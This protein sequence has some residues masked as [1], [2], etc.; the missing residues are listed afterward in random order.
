MSGADMSKN[1]GGMLSQT[2]GA[3]GT[4]GRS[5]S[6]SLT[7]NIENITRPDAD[8]TDIASQQGLMQWQN[9]MGRT[10]EAAI[11]QSN[12]QQLQATKIM[13][14]E[15]AKETKKAEGEARIAKL[16]QAM[17]GIIASPAAE[18]QGA[19]TALQNLQAA[20]T[21]EALASGLSPT[22]YQDTLTT[23][24]NVAL[25][26]ENKQLNIE[27]QQ[28][29]QIEEQ[30][31]EALSQ[32]LAST[33]LVSEEG[34]QKAL[35]VGGE[36]LSV[37]QDAIK[38]AQSIA[39]NNEKIATEQ[40]DL[41]APVDLGSIDLMLSAFADDS[42]EAVQLRGLK[43]RVEA[44]N[45]KLENPS[46]HAVT[47]GEKTKLTND[48]KKILDITKP[49]YIRARGEDIAN[50]SVYR[51]AWKSASSRAS[52]A[53]EREAAIQLLK[54]EEIASKG[55]G[56]SLAKAGALF[57]EPTGEEIERKVRQMRF[58]NINMEHGK[59][60]TAS[61]GSGGP[62]VVGAGTGS[63]GTTVDVSGEGWN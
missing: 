10:K 62:S 41:K 21:S 58:D 18:T 6:D 2:A 54:S 56:I 9:N 29:K 35:A 36:Y 24:W 57:H 3:L 4:M 46:A 43:E 48:I 12:M 40:R 42:Q 60:L 13:E 44:H 45:K 52:T 11:T 32:V 25:D 23:A 33:D 50:D 16:K 19:K 15:K 20:I 63:L 34:Q 8:P 59:E 26:H 22:D 53:A 37:V 38:A 49:A 5:Y 27:S 1:L 14:A 31:L 61:P 28:A 51:A 17:D 30:K 55:E 47:I 7:R 39:E